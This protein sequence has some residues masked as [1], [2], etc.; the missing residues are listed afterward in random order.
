[1]M[2]SL[3]NTQDRQPRPRRRGFGLTSARMRQPSRQCCS[4]SGHGGRM[5][6]G[7]GS[8]EGLF[9]SFG[10]GCVSVGGKTCQALRRHQRY[11]RNPGHCRSPPLQLFRHRQRYG[12]KCR[13]SWPLPADHA[14]RWRCDMSAVP[15]RISES[16]LGRIRLRLRSLLRQAGAQHAP[17]QTSGLGHAGS[18][19][20]FPRFTE[21]SR[22]AY[23][24]RA[25][26]GE[27]PLSPTEIEHARRIGL[28]E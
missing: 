1:M 21:P 9:R 16:S 2:K 24:R 14:Q 20:T 10:S 13:Q 15:D 11:A 12:P 6:R 5:R 26:P 23:L 18:H 22:G 28:I 8:R 27:T 19:R 7:K 17:E 25:D 3:P 4:P